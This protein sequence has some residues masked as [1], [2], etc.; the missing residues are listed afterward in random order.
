[1]ATN[2]RER[3]AERRENRDNRPR[4]VA[5]YIRISP[6]KVRYVIDQV[7]GK[8]VDEAQAI[9]MY[10]PKGASEVVEKLINSAAANAENNQDIP[11]DSLYIAEIF[12]NAGPTMKR[13]IPRAKGRATQILK[14]SSHI[15]VILDQKAN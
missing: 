4:A 8:S 3:A 13:Y 1:M 10:S 11:R 15:T 12:C 5:K 7:R 14:R 6:Q 9:L 2:Q